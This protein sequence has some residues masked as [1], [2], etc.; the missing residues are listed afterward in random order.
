[1]SIVVK[2]I[3]ESI[4]SVREH[5]MEPCRDYTARLWCST[6]KKAVLHPLLMVSGAAMLFH[7]G[8]TNLN[9]KMSRCRKLNFTAG[10]GHL[11]MIWVAR[12]RCPSRRPLELLSRLDILELTLPHWV[13]S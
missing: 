12:R 9:P 1:M 3:P 8:D 5:G 2:T 7:R 13:A 4:S 10:V 6:S 11:D